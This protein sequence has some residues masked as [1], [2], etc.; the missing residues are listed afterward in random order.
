MIGAIMTP[1]STVRVAD[2]ADATPCEGPGT[3]LALWVQGC[4]RRCEGCCNP[5]MFDE[6]GGRQVPVAELVRRGERAAADGA[7][8]ISLLGGEPFLQA[9]PLAELAEAAREQGLGVAVFTGYEL[10]ELQQSGD[11]DALRLLAA[12]DLLVDGP[13]LHE[14]RSSRRRWIGS[15]NQRMHFLTDRYR[16]HPDILE[17]G[18]QGVHIRIA[19]GEVQLS[20]WPALADAVGPPSDED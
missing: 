2:I 12:T 3:R 9:G 19:D 15:D 13:Y 11:E 18:T 4:Q 5:E 17:D 16:D 10:E 1:P 8:G 14:Q 6:D 7:E 20:G